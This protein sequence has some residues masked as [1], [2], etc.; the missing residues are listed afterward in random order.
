MSKR[1]MIVIVCVLAL[2]SAA[3]ANKHDATEKIK[4]GEWVDLLDKDLS[5]WDVY[6]S[7]PGAVIRSVLN[8][9]APTT[10]QPIGLNPPGQQI[11]SVIEQ[12]GKPVLKITGEIY[13]AVSTKREYSNYDFRAKIKWGEKKWPPRLTEPR[14]SGILYNSIGAYA[15]DYWHSWMQS[16]EF[17]VIEGGMGDYW[18]IADSQVDVPA[19][20]GDGEKFYTYQHG[21]PLVSFG[22]TPGGDTASKYCQHGPSSEL[23]DDWNQLELICYGDKCVHIV[24][25]KV[26]MALSNSRSLQNGTVAPLTHGK[27]QIQSEAAEAYYKDIQIRSISRI[28]EAYRQF[29]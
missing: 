3:S 15:A 4:E 5:Q 8:G 21:A 12:Q 23:P 29:F 27:L 28:P 18:S 11:F 10:L 9:T 17:Q 26:V 24:N 6:L 19:A 22:N 25:G 7:Y 2:A 13:G 20:R 14:D 16:Q 1:L